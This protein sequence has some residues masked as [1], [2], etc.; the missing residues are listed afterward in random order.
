VALS[1]VQRPEDIDELR[2]LTGKR[3]KIMAKLEKPAAMDCLEAVNFIL[4]VL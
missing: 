1:F 2:A 3:V 4:L